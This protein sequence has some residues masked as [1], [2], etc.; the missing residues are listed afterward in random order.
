MSGYYI[1]VP[2]AGLD[3]IFDMDL[4]AIEIKMYL[5]ILRSVNNKTNIYIASSEK[6]MEVLKCSY[7]SVTTARAKLVKLGLI[8][9]KCGGKNKPGYYSI[10]YTSK[11][12]EKF[13]RK[14]NVKNRDELKR[15]DSAC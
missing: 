15:F 13:K 12:A 11:P 3:A 6:L 14:E 9:F 8:C 5:F 2:H 4:Q 7:W 1:K 10:P